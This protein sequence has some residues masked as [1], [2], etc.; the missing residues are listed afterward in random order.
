MKISVTFRNGEGENWQKVYAEEKMQ[1]LKKYLDAPAEA[2]III[3]MEKFRNAMEINLSSNGWNINA[4]EEAKDMRIALDRC[5]EKI[6]K[7]LKK[8]REKVREH[9][10]KSIRQSQEKSASAEEAEEVTS[11]IT[12]T[13]KIILKPMSFDEAI[14]ELDEKNDRFIIYRDSSSE[15]VSI[16]YR[17]D[18]GNFTLIET[19]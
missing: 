15:N 14:M 13:R 9:K 5:V 19:N 16:V 11:K 4:K 8:Q 6:E 17:R 1:K 2:H 10:P 3:S 18:D 7:Q 12:E